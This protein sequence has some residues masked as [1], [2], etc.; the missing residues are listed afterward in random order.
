MYIKENDKRQNVQSKTDNDVKREILVSLTIPRTAKELEK[1]AGMKTRTVQRILKVLQNKG[2]VRRM[3]KAERRRANWYPD[4]S[5]YSQEEWKEHKTDLRI[6]VY[7]SK[8]NDP[9]E[10][11]ANIDEKIKDVKPENSKI[12]VDI[13]L[14]RYER[15]N[16]YYSDIEKLEKLSEIWSKYYDETLLSAILDLCEKVRGGNASDIVEKL[17]KRYTNDVS[18]RLLYLFIKEAISGVQLEEID[19][20][21]NSLEKLE[22]EKLKLAIGTLHNLVYRGGFSS[23]LK[24]HRK[25]I[26]DLALKLGERGIETEVIDELLNL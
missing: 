10:I 4:P 2:E 18:G 8:I 11:R 22:K 6:P 9:G 19:N 7:I 3:S 12:L 16:P 25:T 14:G 17:N 15:F 21:I 1:I 5:V 20:V 24:T 13:I 23:Y 26:M